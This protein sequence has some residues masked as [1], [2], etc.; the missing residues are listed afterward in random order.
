VNYAER[1]LCSLVAV[2]APWEDVSKLWMIVALACFFEC[3]VLNPRVF[4]CGSR[5]PGL[6]S[7]H[8]EPPESDLVICG[9]QNLWLSTVKSST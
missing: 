6:V 1:Y 4:A 7:H 2:V 5:S 9:G 3:R 8:D